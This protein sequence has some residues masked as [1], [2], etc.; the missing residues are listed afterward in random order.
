MPVIDRR[1]AHTAARVLVVPAALTALAVAVPQAAA[2]TGLESSS[3]GANAALAGLPPRLTLAFSDPMTQKYA[4]VAV[5]GPDG[6]SVADGAPQAD[7]ETVTLALTS[8]SAAGRYT[9]GYRVV[10]QDGHPVSGSYTFTVKATATS[11]AAPAK[12]AAASPEAPALKA[13][14]ADDKSSGS[15]TP[16]LAAAGALAVAGVIGGVLVRR[17]RQARDG[18]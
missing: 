1:A 17:R 13:Q 18:D 12:E 6:A 16:V 2:H 15:G 8:G 11:P 7:G 10:S 4:K 9:V 14:E 5:T 3:P